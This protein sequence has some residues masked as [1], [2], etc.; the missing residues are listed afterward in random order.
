MAK[1]SR[2]YAGVYSVKGKKGTS[3]G[4]DYIHPQAGHR[5]R[6]ILKNVTSEKDAADARAAEIA[7]A[8]R[9]AHAKAY[10]YMEK[11]KTV[12]FES[13]VK[14]YLKWYEENPEKKDH[15][16]VGHNAKPLLRAFKGKLMSDITPWV[17]EKYRNARVNEVS[18]SKVNS[19]LSTGSGIF[20]LAIERGH[21]DGENPF[22][23]VKRLRVDQKKTKAIT[24]GQVEA[25][26]AEIKYSTVRDMAEFAYY[27]GWRV[28]EIRKL[29]WKDVDFDAGTAW[30]ADPKNNQPVEIVLSET[31]LE[32]VK[33][34][35]LRGPEDHVFCKKN[36]K[37]YKRNLWTGIRK[38]AERAGV[39][40][41]PRKAWHIFRHTWASEMIRNVQGDVET[42]RVMG[43]WKTS[44]MPLRY[45]SAMARE[46]QKDALGQMPKLN[47]RKVAEMEKVVS[48]SDRTG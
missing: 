20:K 17:V 14:A 47:G 39:W 37:P 7:D 12:P 41:P 32:I 38:A 35:P 3:Y 25:I 29:K 46:R 24:P 4:I 8:K 44:Q 22:G 26:L 10:G 40:L 31:A 6:K 1:K 48:I 13:M 28:G 19:E 34:Q 30:L 18:K 16:T 43:N 5:V 9:G 42:L 15:K 21:Y 27:S 11:P 36:G 23:K 45:A 33:R 2:K